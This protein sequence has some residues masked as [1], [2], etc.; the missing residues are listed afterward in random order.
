MHWW[1][2]TA[3]TYQVAQWLTYAALVCGITGL[4]SWPTMRSLAIVAIVI[5]T[6]ATA[7]AMFAWFRLAHLREIA[8]RR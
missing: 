1:D 5:A 8:G 3:A 7:S 2:S 6:A 4:F